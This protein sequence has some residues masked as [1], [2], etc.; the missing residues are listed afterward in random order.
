MSVVMAKKPVRRLRGLE[1][2]SGARALNGAAMVGHA[3]SVRIRMKNFTG[4]LRTGII[5]DLPKSGDADIWDEA[6]G[7]CQQ[8]II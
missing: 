1:V 2:S 8:N 7:G 4:N 5:S 6:P 3:S